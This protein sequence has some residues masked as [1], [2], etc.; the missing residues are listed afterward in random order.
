MTRPTTPV[1]TIDPHDL[2]ADAV[3]VAAARLRAVAPLTVLSVRDR[4]TR[5]AALAEA[6][7]ILQRAGTVPLPVV[8]GG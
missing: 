1:I 5:R 6:Q 4:K 2:D 7:E 3:E 8:Y